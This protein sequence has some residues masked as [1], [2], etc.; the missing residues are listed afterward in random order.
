MQLPVVMAFR[1]R[2]AKCGYNEIHI[3]NMKK[4]FNGQEIYKVTA[5][6]PFCY[7]Y[8]E[9]YMTYLDMFYWR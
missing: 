4:K 6:D 2:L 8:C 5:R 1:A 7:M 9:R 3:K